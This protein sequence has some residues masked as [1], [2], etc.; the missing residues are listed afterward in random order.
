MHTPT[1]T[2]TQKVLFL[3]LFFTMTLGVLAQG[4]TVAHASVCSEVGSTLSY[5]SSDRETGGQVS[6]LQRF[7]IAT[8][9]SLFPNGEV[10]GFFGR[11]TER[12]VQRY[13]EREGLAQGGT[14]DSTGYGATGPRTRAAFSRACVETSSVS[15]RDIPKIDVY[16]SVSD[17]SATVDVL[18]DS[19]E[20]ITFDM[21]YKSR[22]SAVKEIGERLEHQYQVDFGKLSDAKRNAKIKKLVRWN[23]EM[24]DSDNSA[25]DS[26]TE[27]DIKDI[28]IDGSAQDQYV[29]ADIDMRHDDNIRFDIVRETRDRMVEAIAEKLERSHDFDFGSFSSDRR[30]DE[31]LDSRTTVNITTGTTPPPTNP[32]TTPSTTITR[33]TLTDVATI[34]HVVASD[35]S[36]VYTITLKNGST[37]TVTTQKSMT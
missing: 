16:Y 28:T 8:E 6:A 22:S 36:T 34:S 18:L 17:Q 32:T 21:S 27:D 20:D 5:G 11:L 15:Y 1:L 14:P 24:T 10:T 33:Y 2:G 19:A 12:A 35:L 30:R 7:L 4:A 37:R 13:Q 9:P 23:E 26:F 25:D 3:C 29:R 31:F